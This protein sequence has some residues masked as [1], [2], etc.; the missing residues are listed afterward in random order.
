MEFADS[1]WILDGICNFASC[2]TQ[3]DDAQTVDFQDIGCESINVFVS[4]GC[5]S[6][7]N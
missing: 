3:Q 1:N 4:G 5:F 6:G 7:L 2:F